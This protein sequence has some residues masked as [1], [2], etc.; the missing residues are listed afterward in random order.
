MG[1][2][3]VTVRQGHGVGPLPEIVLYDSV[4]GGAG[5]V[6]ELED[7]KR[8]RAALKEARERVEGCRGCAPE[9]SCYGC[10]RS[11]ANQFAHAHLA[12]GP[13]A[14]YL[15]RVLQSWQL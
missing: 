14:E 10:L 12:R 7:P 9:T 11:F 6:A 3:S 8:F 13:V 5:L 15:D 1:A 4:P 2:L